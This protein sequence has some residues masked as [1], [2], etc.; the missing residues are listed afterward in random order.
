[1]PDWDELVAQTAWA[2]ARGAAVHLDGARI[3]EAGPYYATT[4]R[5]TLSDIAALADTVYVS[6]Y[7][8]LAGLA[9]SCVAGDA[10]VVAE[11]SVW[12]TRHGGRIF[13]MWPYAASAMTVFKERLPKM[14]RYYRHAVAIG[15]ALQGVP[16]VEVLPARVQAPMMHLRLPVT[17]DEL[18]TR[19][20]GIATSDGIWTFSRPFVSEGIRLQRC[21][22]S[23]GD[24]TLE[25]TPAEMRGVVE[26]LATG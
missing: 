20:I 6:F 24:A 16:G 15:K 19:A 12:R 1:L 5:K 7:K 23:V 22:L 8:G 2:R 13:A 10:D 26:R 14:A 25:I 18:R 4:R 17:V 11:L 21:E 9:G 3:F